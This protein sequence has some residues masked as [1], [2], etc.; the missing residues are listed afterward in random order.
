MHDRTLKIATENV[1]VIWNKIYAHLCTSIQCDGT[2]KSQQMF[3]NNATFIARFLSFFAIVAAKLIK[4]LG[5]NLV[6][7][8][9]SF[10]VV[11]FPLKAHKINKYVKCENVTN[12]L[13]VQ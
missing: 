8:F 12:H 2:T 10:Y 7:D 4:F 11:Y 6:I 3:L 13:N 5:G 9:H 1:K